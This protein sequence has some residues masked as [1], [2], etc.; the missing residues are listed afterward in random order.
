MLRSSGEPDGDFAPV[1]T[2][3]SASAT[4]SL[5]EAGAMPAGVLHASGKAKIVRIG[6]SVTI[7][8]ADGSAHEAKRG[9][10]VDQD[11]AIETGADSGAGIAFAD[12]TIFNLSDPSRVLAVVDNPDII[13]VLGGVSPDHACAQGQTRRSLSGRAS[14]VPGRP[15]GRV[16]QP[17]RSGRLEH[18][19]RRSLA[20]AAVRPVRQWRQPLEH[21]S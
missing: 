1:S 2:Q 14:H 16:F 11:D 10:L 8:R 18:A 5:E 15:T 17:G 20:S 7:F 12:G 3:H 21:Q 9:D 6:G 13:V 19:S 4:I